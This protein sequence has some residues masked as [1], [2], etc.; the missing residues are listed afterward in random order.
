MSANAR[1]MGDASADA[2]PRDPLIGQVVADRYRITG[3]LGRGG[4]GTVY[5]ATHLQMKR[6]VALKV[7]RRDLTADPTMARRF[8]REARA[9]SRVQG[10]GVVTLY[11]FGRSEDGLLYIAMELLEGE[12]LAAR[13]SREGALPWRDAVTIARAIA[14]ALVAAHQA[15][16]VHRDLKP[17]NVSINGAGEVRVLDFG[18]ARIL[19]TEVDDSSGELPL[20]QA[21]A[22][23]GT[24]M[25][26]SPEASARRAVGPSGDLYSLGVMLF[27]MVV[28]R[29]PFEEDHPVLLM[30]AHVR[31]P[32]EL[33]REA[34]AALAVPDALEELVD[35]L[36]AKTPEERPSGAAQVVERLEAIAESQ[37]SL[38][39]PIPD[40]PER[41]SAPA[42]EPAPER[43]GRSRRGVALGATA[44]LLLAGGLGYLGWRAASEPAADP[45][46][47][48]TAE[49]REA[50][51]ETPSK[52]TSAPA[53]PTARGATDP[54]APP[55]RA[56]AELRLRLT[57]PQA[58]VAI[59]GQAIGNGPF[60]EPISLPPGPH[61]IVARAGGREVEEEVV[62]AP[63][64]PIELELRVPVRRRRAAPRLAPVLPIK[65]QR[66][67]EGEP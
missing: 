2:R 36:L 26:M 35:E 38:A 8:E 9:A 37:P 52:V 62:A 57:P 20:T 18:I 16:V 65:T 51:H 66:A 55:A 30:G 15:D 32:P 33:L 40:A 5:D 39:P 17:E 59:D 31:V 14:E 56:D 13:L 47:A 43:A 23:V 49:T 19:E 34:D 6:R 24:P 25:Y 3:L 29:P 7:L 4:M 28:G 64:E 27:E 63:G 22:I 54:I 42:V 21:G 10:P 60:L 44:A 53:E 48:A 41:M 58:E 45:G 61:V 1:P 46:P 67:S 50:S 12:S 11:D